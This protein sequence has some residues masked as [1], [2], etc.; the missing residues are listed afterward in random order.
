MSVSR[1]FLTKKY[2]WHSCNR[3]NRTKTNVDIPS[4]KSIDVLLSCDKR[5]ENSEP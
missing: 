5:C 4:A 3:S 2:T 1:V